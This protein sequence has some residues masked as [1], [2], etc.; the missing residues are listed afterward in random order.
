VSLLHPSQE[1]S[2]V[3]VKGSGSQKHSSDPNF[4]TPLRVF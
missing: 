2:K 1:H 4:Y 3:T